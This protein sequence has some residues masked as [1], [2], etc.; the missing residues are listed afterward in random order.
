M[1]KFEMQNSKIYIGLLWG[2]NNNKLK[3]YQLTKYAAKRNYNMKIAQIVHIDFLD[4]MLT[5]FGVEQIDRVIVHCISDFRDMTEFYMLYQICKDLKIPWTVARQCIFS[6]FLAM[7]LKAIRN[8][9][10]SLN[11]SKA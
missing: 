8:F 6:V 5:D 4:L 3:K 1:E 11:F 7:I 10:I 2:D 9:W